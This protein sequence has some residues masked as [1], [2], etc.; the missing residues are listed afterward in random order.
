[1]KRWYGGTLILALAMILALRYGLMNIQPKRQSA[2]DFFRNHPTTDSHIKNSD[3]LESVVVKAPERPHLIHVE[4]LGDLIAPNNLTKRESEAL[5]L[6]SHMHPLLSR[7]DALPETIQGVKEASVAWND[8]LTA[9]EAEKTLK[10]G[11][12]NNSKN[13]ICPSSVSSP[14][15][16]APTGGIILEIPCGL[17]EDSSITLVGIPNGQQRGFQIELLGSHASA[18][19]NPPIILHYNVSLPGDNM[20]EESFIVQ[21]TWTNELKWG[22]E[23]KCPTHISASSHKGILISYIF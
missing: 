3:S 22:K 14:D 17:V 5:L 20:S 11:D 1:M 10:V 12:T 15:K 7:S 6:W 9:I 4:G 8:L 16:I 18:E 13:E 19:P 23:E 2:Y 21:N